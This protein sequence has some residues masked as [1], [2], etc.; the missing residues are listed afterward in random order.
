[1]AEN[2][3]NSFWK[4]KKVFITGHTGFKGGWTSIWLNQLGAKI[5]GYSLSPKNKNNLFEIC[6]IES[7]VETDLNNINNLSILSKSLKDFEPDILIHMAAQPLV[8]DSY[9]DPIETFNTNVIGTAYVLEASR[10]CESIKVILNI[11]TDKCYENSEQN[12]SY[13][14]TDPMGGYDPYSASK[15]CAELVIAAYRRSFFSNTNIGVASVRAGNVIGGGDWSQ[16]RLIPDIL[17]AFNDKRKVVIRNP[18]AIR[19]WQHV[20][21]PLAGYLELIEKLYRDPSEY[22]SGWN[23]GPNEEDIKSVEWITNYMCNQFPNSKWQIDDSNQLHEAQLLQLDIS[24][25][26]SYLNWK[27]KWTIETSLKK[28]I[29]W[30]NHWLSGYDMH[31]AC[32]DD[33]NEYTR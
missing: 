9:K 17:D 13:K 25:A 6:N 8:I 24:K 16:N 5:K 7:F 26:K 27:P 30:H 18:H 1:M 14:E 12:L 3:K 29:N 32:L 20:L 33:I 2:N 19:P 23:F 21:E 31:R 11:T 22:S 15:G 10:S 28:I 4:D